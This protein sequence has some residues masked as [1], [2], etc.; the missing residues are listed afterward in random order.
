MIRS[1][2]AAHIELQARAEGSAYD[3][4]GRNA[5]TYTPPLY[6]ARTAPKGALSRIVAR[7]INALF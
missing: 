4:V 6:N 7:I 3:R 1:E 2:S 5:L